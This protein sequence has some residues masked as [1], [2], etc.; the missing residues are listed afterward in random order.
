MNN[1]NRTEGL[2]NIYHKKYLFKII[3]INKLNSYFI[4]FY[5]NDIHQ[6]ISSH[7][8]ILKT[9]LKNNKSY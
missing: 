1:K 6:M 4:Y 5:I 3:K 8:L 2:F 7:G 9:R